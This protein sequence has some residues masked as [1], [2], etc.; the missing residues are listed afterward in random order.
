MMMVSSGTAP[1]GDLAARPTFSA[2]ASAWEDS[3]AGMMPSVRQS[4][5][6]A[7]MASVSVIGS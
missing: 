1:A 4:S 2:P 6:K 7:S 3:M 5:E